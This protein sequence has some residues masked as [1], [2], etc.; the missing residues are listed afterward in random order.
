M[1]VQVFSDIHSDLRALQKAMA[2][3]ADVYIC[4][5]DLV[6]WSQGLDACGEVLR[7]LGEKLWVLPG[8]HETDSDVTAFCRR[9]GFNDFHGKSFIQD[10]WNFAGLGYS[11]PTPFDTP[12]EYSEEELRDRLELFAGLD[13]LILICHAPPMGTALD[14]AGPGNHFGSVAVRKFID[15]Y[16]PSHFFCGH[17]HEAAGAS[18]RIGKTEAMNVGPKGCLLEIAAA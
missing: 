18:E 5:G 2:V 14:Q 6:N 17:I 16:R 11:N 1:R 3:E 12:G 8:N 10:G 13:P 4:A 9:F 7:Q 15:A